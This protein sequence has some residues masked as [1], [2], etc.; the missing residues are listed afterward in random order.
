[1]R[2]ATGWRRWDSSDP[3]QF[4][5]TVTLRVTV[6]PD[7]LAA[8]MVIALNPVSSGMPALQFDVPSATP[9][10]PKPFDQATE[11]TGPV[12]VPLK[13]IEAAEVDTDVDPGEVIAS[14]IGPLPGWVG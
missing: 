8:V 9:D 14:M 1:M 6:L 2:C 12:V 10:C 13:V 3:P 5:V 7:A 4:R 11:A